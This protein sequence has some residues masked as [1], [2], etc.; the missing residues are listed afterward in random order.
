M[1]LLLI[2]L[3]P[4]SWPWISK[5]IWPHKITNKELIIHIIIVLVITCSTY[6][7]GMI[8]NSY[9]IEVWNGEV[10]AKKKVKVSCN[11]SYECNCTSFRDSKGNTTRVCQTCYDHNYDIDWDVYSNVMDTTSIHRIDTQGL[12]EPP[13]WTQ[14][15]IGEPYSDTKR[16][17]NYI[18]GAPD[19]LFNDKALITKFEN[20]LPEYPNSI[21]DYYKINRV[22][23]VGVEVPDLQDWN[24]DLSII[25]KKLGP[26]KKANVVIVLVNTNDIQYA[27]ALKEHWLGGKKNDTV[28]VIGSTKYPTIDF[29]DVFSWSKNA[30]LE[31]E[32]R[33]EVLALKQ[34]DR[35]KVIGIIQQ[36]IKKNFNKRSNEEYAYLEEEAVP[37][38]WLLLFTVFISFTVSGVVSYFTYKEDF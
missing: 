10:T 31:V 13:R 30:S 29:V 3:I 36:Q 37:P 4:L 8:G 6:F 11:H 9:D 25:L 1:Y 23:T 38:V 27:K 15:Q 26:E 35:E 2:L 28:V 14:I 21:Y 34:L 5:F 32:L 7:I 12:K 33:N 16:F 24:N 17:K 18:K 22:L 19:S 20:K